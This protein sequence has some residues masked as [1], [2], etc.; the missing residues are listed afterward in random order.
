M[1]R[2][3]IRTLLAH[4]AAPSRDWAPTS[5]DVDIWLDYLGDLD[6]PDAHAALR[7]HTRRTHHQP[8]PADLI[9]GVKHLRADRL[10]RQIDPIPAADPDDVPG[11]LEHLRAGRTSAGSGRH[12]GQRALPGPAEP[13]AV[14]VHRWRQRVQRMLPARQPRPEPASSTHAERMASMDQMLADQA[15][16]AP[17]AGA[18]ADVQAEPVTS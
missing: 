6:Y 15:R 18:Q 9:A 17:D 12:D 16:P 3:E 10:N 13:P 7:E 11:Y 2:D 14:D 4:A 1:T 5:I 8:V